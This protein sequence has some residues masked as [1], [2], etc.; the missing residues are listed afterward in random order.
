M[1][2]R[3]SYIKK[4]AAHSSQAKWIYFIV[5]AVWLVSLAVYGWATLH[6]WQEGTIMEVIRPT[7]LISFILWSLLSS[8]V[9]S[10]R[11]RAKEVFDTY[12]ETAERLKVSIAELHD[13]GSNKLPRYYRSTFLEMLPTLT[14]EQYHDLRLTVRRINSK[15]VEAQTTGGEELSRILEI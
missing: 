9:I 15:V 6:D 13:F 14:L 11:K 4:S 7:F 8:A 2:D 12:A 5:M 3:A 10:D 1:Q